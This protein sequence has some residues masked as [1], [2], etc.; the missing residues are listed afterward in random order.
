M[1]PGIENMEIKLQMQENYWKAKIENIESQHS[2]D[3]DRLTTEL[4]TTQ[5]AADR[6]KSEYASKVHDLE[7]QSM[8]QSNILVEQRKQLNC[9]SREIT[10]SQT[11]D[12]CYE[13][14][15]STMHSFQRP[16]LTKRGNA[17]FHDNN[18]I[19]HKNLSR[20]D[21]D[22]IIIEDIGSESSQ[23]HD[24]NL[25]SDL[26]KKEYIFDKT[27]NLKSKNNTKLGSDISGTGHMI[28]KSNRKNLKKLENNGKIEDK[29]K[30]YRVLKDINEVNRH[31]NIK[32]IDQ[33]KTFTVKNLENISLNA[34]NKHINIGNTERKKTTHIDDMRNSQK[35]NFLENRSVSSIT[36]SESI[37]S[38]SELA[39]DS[40]SATADDVTVKKYEISTVSFPN[41]KKI[42]Q[43]NTLDIFNNRLRDLGID[44]EW[45]GIPIVTFKQKM[46]ILRH[47]QNI[48]SKKLIHYNQIKQEILTAVLRKISANHN[49]LKNTTSTK[50]FPSHKLVTHIKPKALKAF[51]SHKNNGTCFN[52]II[53]YIEFFHI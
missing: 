47:Q 34:S 7:K 18:E 46:E 43:E 51:N 50:I 14:E 28:V 11:Y 17:D 29:V 41:S 6:I 30:S 13:K 1:T 12:N 23:E 10:N 44:P 2:K 36:E 40:G 21:N 24:I 15:K 27:D 16:L 39:S 37:S 19:Y 53:Y 38:T 49:E 32:D 48:N 9:L 31:E 45:Q 5:Q 4:K 35:S 26:G 22:E 8:D 25:S 52:I 33:N 3:I 42:S 20:V